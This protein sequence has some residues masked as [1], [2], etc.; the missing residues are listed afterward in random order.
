[1]NSWRETAPPDGGTVDGTTIV[2]LTLLA[3]SLAGI[4]VSSV[5]YLHA[6]RRRL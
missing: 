6:R 3:L 1:M 4:V 5:A 2:A